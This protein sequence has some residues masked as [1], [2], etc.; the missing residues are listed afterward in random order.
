MSD[1]GLRQTK[2]QVRSL[3]GYDP[4]GAVSSNWLSTFRAAK[5]K[6]YTPAAFPEAVNVTMP[7]SSIA[8]KPFVSRGDTTGDFI[9][10]LGASFDNALWQNGYVNVANVMPWSMERNFV[11]AKEVANK[12]EGGD[13]SLIGD[14][15]DN[16]AKLFIAAAQPVE[17]V[18]NWFPNTV[19]DAQL[20][21]RADIYS[22]FVTG[23]R[24][25]PLQSFLATGADIPRIGAVNRVV[26]LLSGGGTPDE[27]ATARALVAS[28]ID[29]P[30]SVKRAIE[31]DPKGD[32]AKYLDDA[33]E[34]RQFSY[35]EGIG[36]QAVNLASMGLLYAVEMLATGGLAGVARGAAGM[37]KGASLLPSVG[38]VIMGGGSALGRAARIATMTAAKGASVMATVQKV[39]LASGM[40]LFPA[41][42]LVESILR[43][44]GNKE[45]VAY[46][47]Q[48]NRTTLVSHDPSVQLVSSFAVNPIGATKMALK[49]ELKFVGLPLV[50]LDKATGSRF[51]RIYN[52]ETVVLDIMAKMYGTT[53]ANAAELIGPGRTYETRGDAF[54]QVLGLAADSFIQKL[55]WTARHALNALPR[56][57]RTH[58]LFAQYG[59]QILDEV[60]APMGLIARFRRD[61]SYHDLYGN[62]DPEIA[63]L[64]TRD[65]REAEKLYAQAMVE[66]DLV[67]GYVD[68]LNPEGQANV[69][70]AIEGMFANGRQGTLRDLNTLSVKHPALNG[71]VKDMVAKGEGGRPFV[72]PGDAVPRAVFD[73]ALSRAKIAYEAARKNPVRMATGVDPILRPKSHPS[74]WAAALDTSEETIAALT[75]ATRTPAQDGLI[76]GFLRQ[77]GLATEAELAAGTVDDLYAKAYS[78]FDTT[79][80][81][82]VRRGAEVD[83][84]EKGLGEAADRVAHLRDTKAGRQEIAD[85]VQEEQLWRGRLYEVRDPYT[86][87]A[88]AAAKNPEGAATDQARR[89]LLN[90]AKNAALISIDETVAPAQLHVAT[91]GADLLHSVERGDD[92]V[93]RWIADL[94]E[95]SGPKF[96]AAVSLYKA[97][98]FKGK[99][100]RPNLRR[101]ENDTPP[102]GQ[103]AQMADSQGFVRS[104]REKGDAPA[105]E[106]GLWTGA[107]APTVTYGEIADMVERGKRG[108]PVVT[109]IT[110]PMIEGLGL[111]PGDRAGFIA[112]LG[113]LRGAFDEALGDSTPYLI[114][115]AA[116]AK[117]QAWAMKRVLDGQP[118]ALSHD[119]SAD[120][121]HTNSL[122]ALKDALDGTSTRP[123]VR[124]IVE[125]DPRLL[126]Q[127]EEVAV[128]RGMGVGDF[129]DSPAS[130]ADIRSIL[131]DAMPDRYTELNPLAE[132]PLDEAVLRGAP[133]ALEDLGAKL[134]EL[135]GTLNE[136]LH[137]VPIELADRIASIPRLT[138]T[139]AADLNGAG[140]G[141]QTLIPEELWSRSDAGA[142][143]LSVLLTGKFHQPPRTIMGLLSVLRDIE[144]GNAAK[145]GMGT[146][147]AAEAQNLGK[148]VVASMIGDARRAGFDVGVMGMGRMLNPYTWDESTNKMMQDLLGRGGAVI[149]R[150]ERGI[151]YGLKARPQ[152]KLNPKT[153][154]IEGEAVAV[155]MSTVPGLAEELLTGRFQ[156]WTE[157]LGTVRINQA[158]GR[159]F[160]LPN[161]QITFE[162]R[163][164]F[165]KRMAEY[166]VAPKAAEAVWT[167]W[168]NYAKESRGVKWKK[169]ATGARYSEPASSALYATEKNIPNSLLETVARD[170]LEDYYRSA[171]GIPESVLSV[172]MAEE[173][174]IAGS[175]TR[176][177]LEKLP[178]MGD[179]LQK[180]Y[181]TFA[182]NEWITTKF[183]LFRFALDARFHAM[184]KV[185]AWALQMG[186]SGLRVPEIDEGMFG[187]N[188]AAIKTVGEMDTM[189]NTGY[190]FAVTRDARIYQLLKIEQPDALRGLVQ[191]DPALFR[192]AMAEVVE[193]DPALAA[194]L[195][196]MGHTPTSY[197]KVMDAYYGKLMR[198]ADPEALIGAELARDLAKTPELAE[199]YSRIYDRNV[200]LL[201][202]LRALMYGNPNRGQ[203]ERALNSF[204]AYW[205]IS[206][207]IKASKWLLNIM[208]GKIGGVR[209]GGLGAL[210]L[211]R[212]QADHER[213]LVE[214]PEYG[215]F[216]E[217][218]AN[219]VFAAQMLFP[220]TPIGM[221]TSMSPLLRN[222][223]FPETAKGV[224]G[225]GP[226][227][228]VTRFLPS[229]AGDL[230]PY[231]KDV[232]FVDAAYK[233]MTGWLP[234][235]TVK[236]Q[237][238]FTPPVP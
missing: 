57:A 190:P 210:T 150:D 65:F 61:W 104:L 144:N 121:A 10:S 137:D 64:V 17:A 192:R 20:N 217:E 19:R 223:F 34:G 83:V 224:L 170:A 180:T 33:P 109:E 123:L 227:Y 58:A 4:Y 141:W 187:M 67:A 149:Y 12:F 216:F 201:G 171:G 160:F 189:A 143:A 30:E 87:F 60:E 95:A 169:T 153:G 42:I 163:G 215:R 165:E 159:L 37:V 140:I 133:G 168:R 195:A 15:I 203:I 2:A 213:K 158:F 29:L 99:Y 3:A 131:P 128:R 73:E 125:A 41:T 117:Y 118:S 154:E 196:D 110:G 44:M 88:S 207:Q 56:P 107:E 62:F 225:I 51:S 172:N 32:F 127:V 93:W 185:E 86:T 206:Y 173:M 102:A 25:G 31:K 138:S 9:G 7:W 184:N 122:W 106:P 97:W 176:R 26:D 114:N 229:I 70:D 38:E 124:E 46:I 198:S 28:M 232:P 27:I 129:L 188:K 13:Q 66:R 155:D 175:F 1:L 157:R 200:E 36:G 162:A 194:M 221:G 152:G 63:K 236:K 71:L 35:I 148:R 156:P 231:L 39:A 182:H 14:I 54:N 204:L 178:V 199:V 220:M 179:F 166:G 55:P 167:A 5:P 218:N 211:D 202:D 186:R 115:R 134:E 174:R 111:A 92:G 230:Y 228:T 136:P 78:Y 76:A 72:N 161:Q 151:Q 21:S 135:R 96:D 79:T 209:T 89:V 77:K 68:L 205:P 47:D 49:G 82:W 90:K 120:V 16:A 226:V 119:Y 181:G 214:D 219:L 183:F 103:A 74:E 59:K 43:T 8:S 11:I 80:A 145:I 147:L 53:R 130:T 100:N 233:S 50:I 85:A 208:Y 23:Q 94:R 75:A 101:F 40:S 146:Q 45:G 212:M 132:T 24:V 238:G 69:A 91:V 234:P 126:A 48:L 237:G 177:Q 84:L 112:K 193:Q 98:A 81:P 197:L 191:A 116:N 164:R 22:S 222:I 108:V 142:K 18:M 113:S 6:G 52:H 235:G 105:V 139:L